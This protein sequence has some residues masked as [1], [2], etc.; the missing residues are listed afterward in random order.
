MGMYFQEETLYVCLSPPIVWSFDSVQDCLPESER[1]LVRA[2]AA[3]F[4][5]VKTQL[6]PLPFAVLLH[7]V[8]FFSRG[9]WGLVFCGLTLEQQRAAAES[10]VLPC[11]EE[12]TREERS[13]SGADPRVLAAPRGEM[14]VLCLLAAPENTETARSFLAVLPV[15]RGG[16]RYKPF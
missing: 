6:C 12:N 13:R 9:A 2:A 15:C 4:N 8:I 5:P 1:I 16:K 14:V 3:L 10:L 11:R 7:F